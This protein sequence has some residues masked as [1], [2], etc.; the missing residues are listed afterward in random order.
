M[1]V[2]LYV[3]VPRLEDGSP[4]AVSTCADGKS[5]MQTVI[6]VP[7]FLNFIEMGDKNIDVLELLFACLI[8]H[9]HR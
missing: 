7:P 6:Q 4:C 3:G 5:D 1:C 9:P 2:A 8:S